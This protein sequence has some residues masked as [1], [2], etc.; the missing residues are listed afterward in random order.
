VSKSKSQPPRP[1]RSH[2]ALLALA[3]L[4]AGP[5]LPANAEVVYPA[6]LRIG[7]EPPPGMHL[8]NATQRFEDPDRKVS[9][10]IAELP[11][12][13]YPEMERMVFAETNQL[14]VTVLKRESFPFASGIG[15]LA[16]VRITVDGVTYRKWILLASSAAAP[17]ADLATLISIQMPEEASAAYPESALRAALA[18]VTFRPAPIEERLALIPFTIGDLGGFQV[19]EVTPQGVVLKD[20]AQPDALPRIS[21]TIGKGAPDNPDDRAR[22]ARDL[23]QSVP[24]PELS[25][26]SAESQRIR[27]QPGFETKAQAKTT[28]GADVA[29]VQWIRFG[30]AGYLTILAGSRKDDW[31]QLYPRFRALRDGIEPR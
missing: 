23:M 11:L 26:V 12:Q 27:G 28:T 20:P 24:L 8:N 3:A 16:A 7:L 18:S 13:L 25:I 6:G 10:A 30:S 15:F 2:W 1:R 21:I 31:E 5:A 9:I 19:V 29:L 22:F 14:G 4:L 17:I